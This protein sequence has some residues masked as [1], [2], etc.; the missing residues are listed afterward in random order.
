M[1]HSA[2]IVVVVVVVLVFSHQDLVQGGHDT[3]LK[4][5]KDVT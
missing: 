4:Q 5:F 1:A 3:T 2:V